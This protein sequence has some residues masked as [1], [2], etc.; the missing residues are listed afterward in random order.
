M[1]N[2]DLKSGNV[3]FSY[4]DDTVDKKNK[5]QLFLDNDI[6]L[7]INSKPSHRNIS[8]SILPTDC[9]ILEHESHIC[10]DDVFAFDKKYPIIKISTISINILKRLKDMVSMSSTIPT[11]LIK[12]IQGILEDIILDKEIMEMPF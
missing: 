6:V 8:I 1:D 9:P 2:E 7:L 10:I 3:Y 5:Y 4:R 11:I 12:R